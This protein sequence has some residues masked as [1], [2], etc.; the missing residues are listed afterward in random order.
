[1]IRY[2]CFSGTVPVSGGLSAAGAV[3][4]NIAVSKKYINRF[5]NGKRF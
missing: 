1:M 2:P 5:G 4:G 3:P